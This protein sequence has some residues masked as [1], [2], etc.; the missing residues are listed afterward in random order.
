MVRFWFCLFVWAAALV[1]RSSQAATR[2]VRTVLELESAAANAV[3]GDE[4]VLQPGVYSLARTVNLAKPNVVI[5]GSTGQREDVLLRGGGMNSR[6]VD[7]GISVAASDVTIRDLSLEEFYFNGI[8]TRAELNV[9]R[10]IISNVKTVNIGER[11]I[12]GSRDASSATKTSDDFLIERVWMLQTKP[13]TGHAD[14][15][16][17]YIGG[18]D[19]MAMRNLVI[20][21]CRAEGIVGSANGGNA[22]IFLWQG[23]QNVIIER[24]QILGCAKGIALGNPSPPASNLPTGSWHADG[25]VIR[26]NMVLRG[27]WTTGNNIGLELASTKNVL[28]AFNTFY[29]S[30]ADYFRVVSLSES[31]GGV[32]SGVALKYNIIR[33]RIFDQTGGSGWTSL[34]NIVDGS[35]TVVIPDWFVAPQA[36]DFHLTPKATRAIDAGALI[37][38]LEDDLDRQLRPDGLRPDIGA[39]EIRSADIDG[40]TIPDRVENLSSAYQVGADD[41]L[42]D[43]DNDGAS[44][45][46]EYYGGTDPLD[47]ASVL[48]LSQPSLDNGK[49]LFSISTAQNWAYDVQFAD[50]TWPL[51]WK[52]LASVQGSNSS[53]QIIDLIRSPGRLY[54]IGAHPAT[55]P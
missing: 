51:Q 29:S 7:E 46:Q 28:C 11:H 55:A 12:K 34:G 52:T 43:S 22:A 9:D 31:T 48:R 39:D 16:P 14:T 27:T 49:F 32:L 41:R 53:S 45:A 37:P 26:N 13:R 21:D 2:L 40:D 44:N 1:F 17:D 15:S 54:R 36:G 4:I 42:R 23:I 50:L 20:R 3:P 30:Q 18:I 25:A 5:R 35:G 24:S 19:M 47:P 6:G 38:G 10:C 8:H 33:G